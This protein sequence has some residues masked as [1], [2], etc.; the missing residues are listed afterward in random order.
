MALLTGFMCWQV[1]DLRRIVKSLSTE[2]SARCFLKE[3]IEIWLT[4][5]DCDGDL[6]KR[7]DD[8]MTSVEQRAA[9]LQHARQQLEAV[10]SSWCPPA[11]FRDASPV[12]E[13]VQTHLCVCP[14]ISSEVGQFD[15][16]SADAFDGFGDSRVERSDSII[17]ISHQWILPVLLE[18]ELGFLNV[19]MVAV[20]KALQSSLIERLIDSIGTTGTSVV[21]MVSD[22][23]RDALLLQGD[24]PATKSQGKSDL[25]VSLFDN[26]SEFARMRSPLPRDSSLASYL[27]KLTWQHQIICPPHAASSQASIL[28][29]SII[30]SLNT[31]RK[32]EGFASV[33]AAETSFVIPTFVSE[34]DDADGDKG[35]EG[36]VQSI[37]QYQAHIRP[38]YNLNVRGQMQKIFTL[39]ISLCLDPQ[40]GHEL[41]KLKLMLSDFDEACLSEEGLSPTSKLAIAIACADKTRIAAFYTFD[42]IRSII[43]R[44]QAATPTMVGS[45]SQD[46][47]V[48]ETRENHPLPRANTLP[49]TA[50]EAEVANAMQHASSAAASCAV[51]QSTV[52][53]PPSGSASYVCPECSRDV[54][55]D[56]MT[57]LHDGAPKTTFEWSNR[58]IA[59]QVKF[60]LGSLIRES[61]V[62]QRRFTAP[63]TQGDWHTSFAGGI[64]ARQLLPSM[65]DAIASVCDVEMNLGSCPS[66]FDS[67]FTSGNMDA[68]DREQSRFVATKSPTCISV[69]NT[70]AE[71]S[72]V[73]C[74]IRYFMKAVGAHR[75][76][77][78]VA[79]P[80]T[81]SEDDDEDKEE[82]DKDDKDI[83]DEEVNVKVKGKGMG[84]EKDELHLV[85]YECR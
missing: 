5:R 31:A 29:L 78:C 26:G 49:V 79:T 44:I 82:N 84:K 42:C 20:R 28:L 52:A 53:I 4:W 76:L 74:Q 25:S 62:F 33:D 37:I 63:A 21:A 50:A 6:S 60:R 73:T 72:Q 34:P 64:P 38:E 48:L 32:S 27:S 2:T 67:Q 24:V 54:P 14:Q 65:V 17:S 12:S 59:M 43:D 57:N 51:C 13:A 83:T 41:L 81:P 40:S 23:A 45:T 46:E 39:Q 30:D 35:V 19:P 47:I 18:I 68:P 80:V 16:G 71:H 77:V 1:S 15:H 7:Q 10:C 70:I 58:T 75:V 61:S 55:F 85:V 36:K 22:I 69:A 66:H 3:K 11:G 56:I 9:D 8:K